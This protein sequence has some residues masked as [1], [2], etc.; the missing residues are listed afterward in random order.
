MRDSLVGP[1]HQED[2]EQQVSRE[3]VVGRVL[4]ELQGHLDRLEPQ[5]SLEC[6]VLKDVLASSNILITPKITQ[7]LIFSPYQRIARNLP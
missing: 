4:Q 3:T 6:P 1:D 5:V 2:R 7:I